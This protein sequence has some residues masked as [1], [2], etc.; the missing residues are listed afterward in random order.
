M[1]EPL[2]ERFPEL[3]LPG[4]GALGSDAVRVVESN[5][6]FVEAFLVGANQEL[7]YELLWRG[8]PSDPRA[9]PFRRFWG[10]VG[11]AEDID[12]VSTWDPASGLGTHV[13]VTAGMILLVRSE[14][15]RRYPSLLVAAVPGAWNTN[16]TRAPSKDP[17]S[18]T[19][20]AFRGRIGADVLYAGFSTPSAADAVGDRT[21]D[22]A[23][24]WFF[25]LSENPGDPRFGLDPDGGTA[26]PTRTTLSWRHLTLEAGEE[27]ATLNAFPAVPD[28]GF[29]PQNA[30]AASLASLVRQRP[31][32]AFIHASLLIGPGA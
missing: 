18:L 13:K 14:L 32:R 8:L 12:D 11:G 31:F 9:T 29:T 27:Y 15:V 2:A 20:P 17:A 24:G 4:A 22:G 7:N 16:G 25:L 10:H 21:R 23:P 5:P 1:S 6:A 26:P 3:M 19:L 30:T 28:A